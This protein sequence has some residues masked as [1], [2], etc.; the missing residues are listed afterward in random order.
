MKVFGH[1]VAKPDFLPAHGQ[2]F[3]WHPG[4][5]K[6]DSAATEQI[7]LILAASRLRLPALKNFRVRP[8]YGSIR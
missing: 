8:P 3:G 4:T 2:N 1:I 5:Q 6:F 7:W